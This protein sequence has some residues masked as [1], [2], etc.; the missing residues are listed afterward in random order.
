MLYKLAI[1][2]IGKT[3]RKHSYRTIEKELESLPKLTYYIKG[4]A[5]LCYGLCEEWKNFNRYEVLENAIQK[6]AEYENQEED[7]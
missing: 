5:Y 7:E 3:N 6:L 1:W 4:K 2:Y